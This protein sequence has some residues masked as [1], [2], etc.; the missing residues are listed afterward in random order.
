MILQAR[1]SD[2]ALWEMNLLL[3]EMNLLRLEMNLRESGNAAEGLEM[4]PAFHGMHLLLWRGVAAALEMNPQLLE[5]HLQGL[6]IVHL[7]PDTPP[8]ALENALPERKNTRARSAGHALKLEKTGGD[9]RAP[10]SR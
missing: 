4:L 2:P 7:K 5:M 9:C 1:E 6:E 10:A 3:R 8:L